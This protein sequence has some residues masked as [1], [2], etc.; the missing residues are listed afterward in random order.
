MPGRWKISGGAVGGIIIAL[1]PIFL[2]TTW[3]RDVLQIP[4]V[5]H[6]QPRKSDV[7]IILGA[8]TRKGSD[9]LPLQAAQRLLSGAD[10]YQEGYAPVVI[11]TGGFSKRTKLIE[12]ELMQPEAVEF[13]I[14]VENVIKENQSLNTWEN[15]TYSLAIMQKKKWTTAIVTT[16]PYHTWRACR[17]FRRQ[18]A[19]VVCVPAEYSL[20]P[21]H[22]I[23]DRFVDNR[24]V[25]REY[26]AI[27]LAWFQGRL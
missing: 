3:P 13:G 26:G 20:R 7:I 18:G 24:A 10:L 25:I 11:V 4:L 6:D 9:K 17:M 14:P 21:P 22:T 15:A 12:A 5:S 1:V 2:F 16:S 19:D 27:I 23:Y 8:G